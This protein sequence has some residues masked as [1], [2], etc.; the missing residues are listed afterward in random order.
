MPDAFKASEEY[1]QG[2]AAERA[3]AGWLRTMGYSILPVGD[4][5]TG[6]R[7]R[8]PRLIKPDGELVAPDLLAFG[9]ETVWVEVKWKLN[10]GWHRKSR[11]WTTGI[12]RGHYLDYLSIMDTTGIPVWLLFLHE[13]D[14]PHPRDVGW[15]CPPE[16][17]TGVYG[18]GLSELRHQI[19]HEHAN[20]GRGGMV[21]WHLDKLSRYADYGHVM[22]FLDDSCK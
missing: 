6:K 10:P 8:G 13:S 14:T 4:I 3:V 17:P 1:K 22:R 15:G 11:N 9:E 5:E 16:C 18:G 20:G 12:E 21:Y 7:F 2:R 19:D